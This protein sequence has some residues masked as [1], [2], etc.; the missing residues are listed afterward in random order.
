MFLNHSISHCR[1]KYSTVLLVSPLSVIFFFC[2][3]SSHNKRD[4]TLYSVHIHY[5]CRQFNYI[6][7]PQ[8]K[9]KI[10]RKQTEPVMVSGPDIL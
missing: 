3:F 9:K 4:C 6:H 7:C 2:F 10:V 8:K 5:T 1:Y